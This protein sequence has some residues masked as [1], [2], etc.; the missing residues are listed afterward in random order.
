[1]TISAEYKEYL[2]SN[3]WHAKRLEALR[4]AGAFLMNC[5]VTC[6]RFVFHAIGGYMRVD[7]SGFGLLQS[8]F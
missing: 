7:G 3:Q 4:G 2:Q 5:P 1:M 8:R 6:R